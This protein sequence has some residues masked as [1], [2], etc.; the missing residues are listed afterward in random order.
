MKKYKICPVC[1]KKNSPTVLECIDCGNDLMGIRIVDDSYTVEP[2][3]PNI[4]TNTTK[5]P[6][7][8]VRICECGQENVVS[9]RK[10]VLCGEDISDI[11][12]TPRKKDS[13]GDAYSLASIDGKIDYTLQC[14][15][16]HIIG[17][18]SELSEYLL[19]K[20]YVSRQHAKFTVTPEGLFL[21]NLSKSNGTYVNN[22]KIE[23]NLAYKLC[24][25]DE[26]GLGG[27]VNQSGRQDAAAYFT[28]R[29]C[30]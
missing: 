18:E 25:G 22:K 27:L 26:I 19:E 24:V 4:D 15:S 1:Q 30:P 29:K 10:C 8:F 9:A 3:N 6:T 7:V 20:F 21:Q 11:I 17:R 5:Q 2:E 14:P 16:E 12:P 28:V 13:C 23:D